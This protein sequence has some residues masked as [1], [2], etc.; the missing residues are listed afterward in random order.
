MG[1]RVLSDY[2]L[3]YSIEESIGEILASWQTEQ[4]EAAVQFDLR[5][6]AVEAALYFLL[7]HHWVFLV[8]AARQ[9]DGG[10]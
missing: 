7:R 3:E 6:A 10:S 9:P 1:K 8:P 5:R 4:G 2:S